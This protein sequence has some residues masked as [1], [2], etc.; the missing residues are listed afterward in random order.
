VVN[1]SYFFISGFPTKIKYR[2]LT[3]R[4]LRKHNL[5][6]VCFVNIT[7]TFT[8]SP[9]FSGLFL[10][11]KHLELYRLVLFDQ[12]LPPLMVSDLYEQPVCR[13]AMYHATRR[14]HKAPPGQYIVMVQ[15]ILG[16]SVHN[17]HTR[18]LVCL[19]ARALCWTSKLVGKNK[20]HTTEAWCHSNR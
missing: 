5:T 19:C 7:I 4:K 20:I 18:S 16:Q 11:V 17:K 10:S 12:S 6:G 3:L 14:V 13:V 8:T 1:P 9:N 15:W 2:I